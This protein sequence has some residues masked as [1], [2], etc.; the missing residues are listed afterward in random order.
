MLRA[1]LTITLL[2][3]SATDAFFFFFDRC[4]GYERCGIFGFSVTMHSGNPGGSDCLEYCYIFVDPALECGGCGIGTEELP[5][6]APAFSSPTAVTPTAP[7]PRPSAVTPTAPEPA[8]IPSTQVSEYDISIQLVG[9]PLNDQTAFNNAVA[10]WE[11]VVVGDLVD[12]SK[13]SIGSLDSDCTVPSVIDDLH[14]CAKYIAIDGEYGVL[15]SAGPYYSR[16][17]N[18]LPI[19]GVM[20][21][22]SADIEFL[23]SDG[24]FVSVILHEMGHILGKLRFKRWSLAYFSPLH[25]ADC[26]VTSSTLYKYSMRQ[27]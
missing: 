8:P 7:V 20:E 11:Q 16:S 17:S 25:D 14:I 2:F 6:S 15:G 4:P 23:K 13:S 5:T 10:R 12:V 24:A 27:H 9:I 18:G 19:A 21:F 26:E 22:D 1:I 3:P